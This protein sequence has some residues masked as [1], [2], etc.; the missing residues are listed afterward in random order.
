ARCRTCWRG[1][2]SAVPE[3]SR[4]ARTRPRY[5]RRSRAPTGP[6][7]R[8]G[9][10][11]RPGDLAAPA[12]ASSWVAPQVTEPTFDRNNSVIIKKKSCGAVG[13]PKSRRRVRKIAHEA[14]E[15]GTASGRFC[16][17]RQLLAD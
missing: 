2:R 6:T 14:V 1:C 16:A 9:D 17:R 11:T 4:T 10:L 15:P 7:T 3:G 13:G 5:L 12:I 8:R